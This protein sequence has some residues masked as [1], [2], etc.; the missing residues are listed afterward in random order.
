MDPK[1][2]STHS[3]LAEYFAIIGYD[4]EKQRGGTSSGKI[5]QSFPADKELEISVF[6]QPLN[7]RLTNKPQ[8]PTFFM[9]VLTDELGAHN[10]VGCFTFHESVSVQPIK[11]DD[12]DIDDESLNSIEL[13]YHHH[14]HHHHSHHL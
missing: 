7:W 3:P 10:Y 11:A 14:H 8:P 2:S 9:F 13:T 4:F 12:D 6:C 1:K 5:V